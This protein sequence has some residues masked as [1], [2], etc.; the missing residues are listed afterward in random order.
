MFREEV[1]ARR[2]KKIKSKSYRRVHRKEREKMVQEEHAALEAAG[3][4]KSDEERELHDRR[5]AEERMG[6][7][8]RESK[9]AKGLKAGG[10]AAWDEDARA[11]M[12]DL[13]RRDEELRRRMEGK[14][15]AGSGESELG[16]SSSDSEDGM[17]S[18]GS[19]SGSR[20]RLKE[21]LED[22]AVAGT[23]GLQQSR[24]AGMAFMQRAEASRKA[25]N[26]ADIEELRHGFEDEAVEHVQ[27]ASPESTGR[28]KFGSQKKLHPSLT[29][30]QKSEAQ[31]APRN[32]FEERLSEDE[33]LTEREARAESEE[34]VF[35]VEDRPLLSRPTS[36]VKKGSGALKSDSSGNPW[37]ASIARSKENHLKDRNLTHVEP[38]VDELPQKTKPGPSKKGQRAS[39]VLAD[40][41]SSSDGEESDPGPGA[42]AEWTLTQNEEMVKTMFAGDD[43]FDDF[44]KEK[45]ETIEVEGDKVIDN[46]LPGW[47]N[48]TGAG[49][50]K[51]EQ[52]RAKGRF[53]TT[54]KGVQED[55]RKD[56]KLDK[57][58]VNEKRV[59]K[60]RGYQFRGET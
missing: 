43:V 34:V 45:R 55:K 10:R 23:D 32:E 7:R 15:V 12:T 48:W 46:T 26:D 50:S 33:A 30:Q 8:H 13:A 59:K 47:G 40:E 4:L 17:S 41:T 39:I 27:V 49:I 36:G 60:V 20:R 18:T 19:D 24:L 53:V 44:N 14:K 58:I 2:I 42:E 21:K 56:A 35:Q 51:R 6:A 16:L 28:L 11:G 3:L 29:G 38:L 22:L 5:R 31:K 37:M 54:I 1:R 57:V 25:A 52:K 9:W